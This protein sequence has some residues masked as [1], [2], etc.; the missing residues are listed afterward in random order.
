MENS[1]T[2]FLRDHNVTEGCPTNDTATGLQQQQQRGHRQLTEYVTVALYLVTSVF[3]MCGNSLTI[4]VLLSRHRLR[5]R[6]RLRT[7]ATCF[8]LN[9]AVADDLFLVCLPLMAYSTYAHRWVFGDVGCRLLN[10]FWGVNLYASIFTMTLMSF[11]RYL[12]VVHPLRSI[13]YRTY[14]KAIVVCA[15]VW[16]LGFLLVLP[17]TLYSRVQRQ[18]CKV[19]LM[20]FHF[21]RARRQI[22]KNGG[23]PPPKGEGKGEGACT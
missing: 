18:D 16:V 7:V 12:A 14:R 19:R 4:F 20:L 8:I 21:C 11:D 1:T 9:L 5:R 17:M 2:W 23:K 22:I 3:G 13:R 10:T 15:V 6:H